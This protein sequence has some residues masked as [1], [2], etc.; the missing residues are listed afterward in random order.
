MLYRMYN[1]Y[2]NSKGDI[3]T[4]KGLLLSRLCRQLTTQNGYTLN[5]F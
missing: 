1:D 3:K 2:N 5:S 4:G